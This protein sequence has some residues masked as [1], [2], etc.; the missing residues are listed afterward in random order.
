M[1]D[2]K[3]LLF[4][5][6]VR[7][8]PGRSKG[9]VANEVARLWASERV[10][11]SA[12]T[13][14]GRNQWKGRKLEWLQ[15]NQAR[16]GSHEPRRA[17]SEPDPSSGSSSVKRACEEGQHDRPSLVVLAVDRIAEAARSAILSAES[18]GTVPRSAVASTL[19]LL[20]IRP[21]RLNAS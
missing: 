11:Y 5:V 6:L 18:A 10:S 13:E 9:F 19:T 4:G 3:V 7:P 14:H 16:R 12:R 15:R 2:L 1:T 21:V 17:A 8:R 20:A